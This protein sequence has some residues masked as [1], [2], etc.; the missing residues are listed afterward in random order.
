MKKITVI[1]PTFNSGKTIARAIESVLNQTY[2]A[3]YE[4][5]I[6]DDASTDDTLE[7]CARYP[8]KILASDTN[9]GGPNKGRNSG[10]KNAT[11]QF[12]AFLDHDDEWLSGKINDQMKYLEHG[13]FVYSSHITKQE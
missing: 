10:I 9:S 1:I 3:E 2:M 11:G 8:V 6:C 4:I 7:I 13:D 5:L 12:I